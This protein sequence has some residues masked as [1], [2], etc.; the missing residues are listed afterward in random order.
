MRRHDDITD[1][2]KH[3]QTRIGI[4]NPARLYA[5]TPNVT[6]P[7]PAQSALKQVTI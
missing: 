2:R 6:L 7:P 5:H 1:T 3:T 4:N